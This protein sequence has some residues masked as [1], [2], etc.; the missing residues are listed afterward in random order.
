MVPGLGRQTAIVTGA[1]SGI[2]AAPARMLFDERVARLIV[3]NRMVISL[4][5]IVAVR[6]SAA[7]VE[8]IVADLC[9]SAGQ[10]ATNTAALP[11]SHGSTGWRLQRA[12]QPAAS[13]RPATLRH[14]LRS[15]GRP[16]TCGGGNLTDA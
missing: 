4:A 1:A 9:E 8:T 3:T 2:L 13:S 15:G 12:S 11:L 5:R 7:P 16:R 6:W 10:V 14:G